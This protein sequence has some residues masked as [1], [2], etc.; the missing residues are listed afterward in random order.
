MPNPRF[1]IYNH[2]TPKDISDDV[3]FDKETGVVWERAPISEAQKWD[4]A[5]IYSYP[6]ANAGR[7]GWRLPTI[8]ELLSLIDPTQSNPALPHGH[9]FINVKFDSLCLSRW[10]LLV[11]TVMFC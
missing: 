2:G 1:A 7:Q 11:I 9:P 5:I 3:V 8:E 4:A 6:N 10:L